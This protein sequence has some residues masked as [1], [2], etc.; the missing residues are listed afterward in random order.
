MTP[1]PKEASDA[2]AKGPIDPSLAL[3][4]QD[5]KKLLDKGYLPCERG[6]CV[7]PDGTGFVAGLTKMPGVTMEM[8]DWW[9]YWH[10]LEDLRYSIWCPTDHLGIHVRPDTLERRLDK[11]LSL[12]ERN[13]N[14]TDV[15]YE[16]IGT[17][18]IVLEISFVS[19]EDF[20]YDMKRFK[21]P[22]TLGA[23]CSNAGLSD[24]KTPLV[25][26][27]H[28]ARAIEGG[29]ELRSR[30]WLGYQIRDKKPRFR[31]TKWWACAP[32]TTPTV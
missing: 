11:K 21:E 2:L 16:D 13:W 14:T 5:R 28:I 20:G 3:P 1:P 8:L 9:F 29:L 18:P 26:F 27:T 22:N 15:V 24:P 25:A 4:I 7:M 10:G 6:Y 17:G 12:K 31:P 23:I 19:P 32:R 30:F